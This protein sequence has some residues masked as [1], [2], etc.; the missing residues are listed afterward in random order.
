MYTG[1]RFGK[2]GGVDN[3]VAPHGGRRLRGSRP[4]RPAAARAH[5]RTHLHGRLL[6]HI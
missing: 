4:G 3:D 6:A 5:A 1:I 2:R